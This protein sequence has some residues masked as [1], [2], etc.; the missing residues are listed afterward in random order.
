MGD[1]IGIQYISA[2]KLFFFSSISACVPCHHHHQY[3][4]H[5]PY[6]K[7]PRGQVSC[8]SSEAGTQSTQLASRDSASTA[9]LNHIHYGSLCWN[10]AI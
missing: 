3:L 2:I 10:L 4:H 8:P 6:S 1:H 5:H 7:A 9:M